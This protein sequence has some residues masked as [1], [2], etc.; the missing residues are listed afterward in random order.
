MSDLGNRLRSAREKVGLKQIQVK[1]RTGINNKTLSGYENG[2]SE[3]DLES[4]KTLAALYKVSYDWLLNGE[5]NAKSNDDDQKINLHTFSS[6]LKNGFHDKNITIEQAAEECDVS[7][8]YITQLM[9]EPKRLPGAT[10]LFNLANLLGVT[11]DYLGGFTDD[12]A[13]TSANTPRPKD[14]AEFLDREEVMFQ[15]VPLTDE[16]K[17]KVKNVLAAVFMDAKKRNK[18]K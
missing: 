8:E 9:N 17:E 16:D 11:P 6:R 3:P 12:P 15:G 7:P 2:V 4:L 14:M 5:S 18:R 13:G 1:E 10:T